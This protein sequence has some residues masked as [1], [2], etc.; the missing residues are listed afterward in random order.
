M[1]ITQDRLLRLLTAAEEYKS[2][3]KLADE[4]I[5]NEIA[6]FNAGY[7]T[8]EQALAQIS[9]TATN[10]PLGECAAV[11]SEERTRYNLTKSKNEYIKRYKRN[12]RKFAPGPRQVQVIVSE[13]GERE[14][15]GPNAAEMQQA[16]EELNAKPVRSY[17]EVVVEMEREELDR[18]SAEKRMA[19][20]IDAEDHTASI[21]PEDDLL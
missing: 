5:R 8:A 11:L 21:G 20:Q 7:Q 12:Q 14:S 17:H 10:A 13:I 19:E 1:P 18:K 4:V 2:A 6:S 16:F 15:A 9:L 3:L